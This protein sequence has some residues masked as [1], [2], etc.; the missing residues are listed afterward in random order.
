MKDPNNPQFFEFERFYFIVQF[1]W[2]EGQTVGDGQFEANTV[3][4]RI[5]RQ[6]EEK[7]KANEAAGATASRVAG[8]GI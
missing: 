4:N 8:G 2:E 3:S 5:K 7:L 6:D 1:A